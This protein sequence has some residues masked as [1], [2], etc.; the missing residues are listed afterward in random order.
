MGQALKRGYAIA[1]T[2]T[3]HQ[4]ALPDL[5]SWAVGHPEKIVDWAWR[6]QKQTTD[7]AKQ[8]VAAHT[9]H[10]ARRSYFVGASNGGREGFTAIQRFPQDFDGYALDGPANNWNR[11]SAWGANT[12]QASSPI[13]RRRSPQPSCW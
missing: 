9:A 2:D 13:P 5:A 10:S 11:L 8:V 3:G 6:S 4:A 12:E 7:L 1:S